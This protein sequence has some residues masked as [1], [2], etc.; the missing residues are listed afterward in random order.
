MV[1]FIYNFIVD[2]F[3]TG[4]LE[5]TH[6]QLQRQWLHNPHDN[7]A[8]AMKRMVGKRKRKQVIVGHVPLT[9]IFHLFLKHRGLSI[10]DLE[11]VTTV[12]I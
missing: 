6:D 2:S 10:F 4:T 7:H 8:V 12:K 5:P 3:L 11:S 1:Y 9:R